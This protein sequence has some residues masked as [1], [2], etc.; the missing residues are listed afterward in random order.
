MEWG[1]ELIWHSVQV[2]A[3]GMSDIH[4]GLLNRLSH[5]MDEMSVTELYLD[6]PCN[7]SI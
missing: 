6:N 4:V 1:S 7:Y 5:Y 2:A 3:C